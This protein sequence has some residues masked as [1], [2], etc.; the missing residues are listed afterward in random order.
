MK[1]ET[2]IDAGILSELEAKIY[3]DYEAAEE[4]VLY[5]VDDACAG[6][7]ASVGLTSVKVLINKE[8]VEVLPI[9][10]VFAIDELETECLENM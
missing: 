8:W 2:T 9:L 10:S 7:P 5:P 3:F 6:W 4:E 1:H